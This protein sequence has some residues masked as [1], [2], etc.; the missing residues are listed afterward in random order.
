MEPILKTSET[1]KNLMRA[2]AGE[3]QARNR[4]TF[5]ASAA[6]KEGFPVIQAVFQ[7]TANQEKEH[8][9]LFYK[10]L[11]E[12]TGDTIH[13]DGGYP[14]DTYDRTLDL[15]KAAR[16]NEFEEYENVYKQFGDIALDEGFDR[17][18]QVFHMVADIEKTH[19]DRF[20]L[21][22]GLLE[23][24]QLFASEVETGWVC[25]NCGYVYHG[26]FAPKYCPVCEHEQGWFIRMELTPY[27]GAYKPWKNL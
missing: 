7:F 26:T 19:G 10:F 14:V 6:K 20:D 8:A 11:Q 3:S 25:L 16:H 5:A 23:R 15:L 18:G 27:A 1:A 21:F 2:F 13:I 4:Y 22:A 24:G 17:V 9:E 12:M